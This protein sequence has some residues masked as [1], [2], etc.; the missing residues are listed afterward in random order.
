M[1]QDKKLKN[2]LFLNREISLLK[3]NQRVLSL[4]EDKR[5]PLLER[6]RFL[7][8]FYSNMDEFFM[9]RVGSLK[10]YTL[11]LSAPLLI[12][13]TTAGYQLELI[14]RQ[15]LELNKQASAVFNKQLFPLLLKE[16]IK[17]LTYKELSKKQKEQADSFFK[18]KMFPILTPMAVDHNHPFPLISTLSLS[19]AVKLFIKKSREPLFARIKVP[20][21]FAGWIPLLSEMSGKN[22]FLSS[23]DLITKHLQN[24]FPKMNISAVMPFRITRN[25][26]IENESEEEEDAEDLLEF[27]EEEIRKRKFAEIVRLEHGPQPDEW[28]L[29]FLKQELKLNKQD[30]YELPRPLDY[31]FLQPLTNMQIPRLKQNPFQ[32]FIAPQWTAEESLFDLIKREDQLV[33]HPFESF[34]AT[35]EK[36]IIQAASDPQ[37]IALKMTLYRTNT[38]SSIVE[39]LISAAHEGKQVVCILELK[40][41]LDEEKNIEWAHKMEK[42]GVHVIYGVIGL[43]VHSK[44]TLIVRKENEDFKTYLHIGTGNYHSQ[45]AKLYTDISLFTCHKEIAQDAVELFHFLTGRSQKKSYRHFLI[46]PVQMEKK[47]FETDSGGTEVCAGGKAGGDLCESQQPGSS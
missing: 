35:V 9:K 15:V 16:D 26:D 32:V 14:H 28:L 5:A 7:E 39:A 6:L 40:A 38:N 20:P 30:I 41:R 46:S 17:F 47:V 33:H 45:T 2:K 11:S 4:A 31:I 13:D 8:I 24:L 44:I 36:F 19:L 12:D 25:I 27:I 10:R 43:K 21:F 23:T 29:S 34:S 1:K 22:H 42:A 37:V 3:F 18:N